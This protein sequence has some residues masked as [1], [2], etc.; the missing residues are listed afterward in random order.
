MECNRH[1]SGIEKVINDVNLER[2]IGD[3]RSKSI[4]AIIKVDVCNGMQLIIIFL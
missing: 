1:V 3:K 2:F 4:Q